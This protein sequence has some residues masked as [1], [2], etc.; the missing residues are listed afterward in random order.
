[1]KPAFSL[2]SLLKHMPQ[3]THYHIVILQVYMF[4]IKI[5]QPIKDWFNNKMQMLMIKSVQYVQA[6]FGN[7]VS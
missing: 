7:T 1:M 2:K 4:Q 6:L 3:F 5:G